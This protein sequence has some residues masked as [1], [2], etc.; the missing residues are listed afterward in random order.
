MPI[1]P[2]ATTTAQ[3]FTAQ[4]SDSAKIAGLLTGWKREMFDLRASVLAN[5]SDIVGGL[6]ATVAD[7]AAQL[8]SINALIGAQVAID[9]TTGVGSAF[10]VSTTATQ[11]ATS[12]LTV[13]AGFTKCA[14]TAIGSAG[15]TNNTAS[16]QY[17]YV[18]TC[19]VDTA[20]TVSWARRY[21]TTLPAGFY[22]VVPA[23][24]IMTMAGLTPGMDITFYVKIWASAAFT[25]DASNGVST[26]VQATF[27]R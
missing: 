26:E 18:Q 16:T 2:W 15:A 13:P 23:P 7:L 14:F 20:G 4:P 19:W 24:G 17:F 25:A 8:V 10:P 11:Y 3:E 5:V 6:A 21:H 12:T 9:S 27:Y 22:G 1:D